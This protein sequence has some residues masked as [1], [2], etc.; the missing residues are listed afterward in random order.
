VFRYCLPAF[1][2][3]ASKAR[4]GSQLSDLASAAGASTNN[5]TCPLV[6]WTFLT[7][8]ALWVTSG[9][10]LA[11]W[12]WLFGPQ[13]QQRCVALGMGRVAGF[14]SMYHCTLAGTPLFDLQHTFLSDF[15]T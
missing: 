14:L 13:L 1:V 8:G 5:Y 3:I 2:Y 15:Q 6:L 7:C 4:K 10:M 12:H 9:V 11:I